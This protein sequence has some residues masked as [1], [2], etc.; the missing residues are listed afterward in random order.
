[1]GFVFT[2]L[3]DEYGE[4]DYSKDIHIYKAH[5]S[6]SGRIIIDSDRGLCKKNGTEKYNIYK[7]GTYFETEEKAKERIS[8]M[9][10]ELCSD[11][12]GWFHSNDN[13]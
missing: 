3:K 8:K 9:G 5:K 1:M 6:V 12:S 2:H 11:C 10:T 13:N 7:K 4:I